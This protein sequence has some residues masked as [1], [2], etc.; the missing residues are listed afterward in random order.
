MSL[1]CVL[2]Y[3]SSYMCPLIRVLEA[4]IEGM[5]WGDVEEAYMCRRHTCGGGIHVMSVALMG[6][7]RHVI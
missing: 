7:G 2:L 4:Y 3:V 6:C 1:I 5:H